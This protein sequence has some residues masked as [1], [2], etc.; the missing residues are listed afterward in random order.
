ML[1]LRSVAFGPEVIRR[2]Y[3][4]LQEVSACVQV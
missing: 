1:S 2:N 3:G 4:E